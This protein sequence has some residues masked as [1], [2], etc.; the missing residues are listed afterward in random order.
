MDCFSP[1]TFDRFNITVII[2][3]TDLGVSVLLCLPSLPL[4]LC[5]CSTGPVGCIGYG[6]EETS[7]SPTDLNYDVIFCM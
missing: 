4:T 6:Y 2:L 1:S 5:A 3:D 7:N